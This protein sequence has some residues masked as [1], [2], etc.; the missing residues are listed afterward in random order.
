QLVEPPE[1]GVVPAGG[2]A[3]VPL[4]EERTQLCLG[5]ERE[6]AERARVEVGLARQ[7]GELGAPGGPV[8]GASYCLAG[9]GSKEGGEFAENGFGL[10]RSSRRARRD[11]Q[12]AWRRG[13]TRRRGERGG[14]LLL[15]LWRCGD[16][17]A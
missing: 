11:G 17:A 2:T 5:T 3:V 1:P 6:R 13:L 4:V 12:R 7:D 10:T 14:G 9:R 8:H 15:V 16:F